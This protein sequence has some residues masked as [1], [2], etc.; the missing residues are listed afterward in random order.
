MMSDLNDLRYPVGRLDAKAIPDDTRLRAA[1][2][3]IRELPE[4]LRSAVQDLSD[5]QLDTPYRPGGWTAR[6]VVHHLA[7]SHMNAHT[8]L[9]LALTEDSPTIRPY[10]EALWAELLDAATAPIEPSMAILNGLHARWSMLLDSLD[11]SE[12]QRNWVHP[13][14]GTLS[15]AQLTCLYGWHSRHHV[16]HVTALRTRMN[17]SD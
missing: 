11:A 8:R 12:F 7:D 2:A 16:A 10:E 4:R 9:R 15:V 5:A 13:A 14:H 3:D 6:Q 1:I 17:W